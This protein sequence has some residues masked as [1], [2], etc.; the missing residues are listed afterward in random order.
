MVMDLATRLSPKFGKH[1]GGIAMDQFG[2]YF[3]NKRCTGCKT[4]V[5]ACRDYYDLPVGVAFRKVYDIEGG[6]WTYIDE[7]ETYANSCFA[8]HLS[9]SCNHCSNPLCVKYCPTTAMHKDAEDGIVKID[10]SK[11]IGCGYCTIACPYNAPIVD[12]KAGRAVKCE[13]CYQR[14]AEGEDP[15]CVSACPLRAIGS[16]NIA[17]LRENH[18]NIGSI[19]P[20]PDTTLTKPNITIKP[21]P[22]TKYPDILPSRI[23]NPE[24]V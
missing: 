18:G 5:M 3:N 6:D 2:F 4:C 22:A 8:Y 12:K 7:E 15:I 9:I 24:E 1:N 11:C 16:G 17:I 14:L 19:Y 13:G 20:M 23:A 21:A 10:G